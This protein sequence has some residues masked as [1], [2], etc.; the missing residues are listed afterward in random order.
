TFPGPGMSAN[1][2]MAI[3]YSLAV[4]RTR[5]QE[6]NWEKTLLGG[7]DAGTRAT[8]ILI[9]TSP[10]SAATEPA[11]AGFS[12]REGA[13]SCP[14]TWMTAT[15]SPTL[16]TSSTAKRFSNNTPSTSL[17]TSESTLSVAISKMGSS[18][19]M[20]SPTSFNQAVKVA[21]ATLSP[22]CGNFNSNV[23]IFV[24]KKGLLPWNLQK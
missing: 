7:G 6:K 21:S 11:T 20:E 9:C 24:F 19:S 13:S 23:D 3:H 10:K 14:S 12:S 2:S 4:W 5:E 1:L 16:I 8:A 17:G 18:R 22:I 15:T